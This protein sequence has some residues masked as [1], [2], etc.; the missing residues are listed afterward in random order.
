MRVGWRPLRAAVR[1][2]FDQPVDLPFETPDLAAH[3]ADLAAHLIE[4]AVDLL[5]CHKSQFYD[6]LA[7]NHRYENE[8]PAEAAG[9]REW[10][11]EWFRHRI[12]PLADEHR[13]LILQTYGAQRGRQVRFVEAFEPSEYGAPLDANLTGRLF[14]FL[15]AA[16]L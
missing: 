5:D 15:P 3:L 13:S 4:T 10:L 7:W 14:P 16:P 12:A 1:K 8:L 11:G 6:W 9:R 2:G